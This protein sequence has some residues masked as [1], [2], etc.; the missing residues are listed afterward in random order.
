MPKFLFLLFGFITVF[1]KGQQIPQISNYNFYNEFYNPAA[2]GLKGTINVGTMVRKQWIGVNGSPFT[3]TLFGDYRLNRISSAAGFQ[4]MYDQIGAFKNTDFKLNYSYILPISRVSNLRIGIAPELLVTTLDA[5]WI[6]IDPNDPAIPTGKIT[7]KAFTFSGGLHYNYKKFEIGISM[8][9][10]LES[11]MHLLHYNLARHLIGITQYTFTV[12]RRI[13][14]TP[15]A[16]V[17]TDFNSS[18]FEF[19]VLS[20]IRNIYLK[21]KY[22]I[23]FGYRMQDSFNFQGGFIFKKFTFIYCYDLTT[24]NIRYYSKGSH[25]LLARWRYTKPK[26]KFISHGTINF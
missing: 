10:I 5:N 14:M 8:Q 15:S 6:I 2:I 17:K 4:V 3:T 25:E 22:Y 20:T 12:N 7:D 24:S 9:R 1:A 13:D 19:I 23:G 18:Q 16:L 21:E 26:K 11:E